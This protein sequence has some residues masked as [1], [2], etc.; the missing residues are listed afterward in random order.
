VA[1][2]LLRYICVNIKHLVTPAALTLSLLTACSST[3]A[4]D[5]ANSTAGTTPPPPAQAAVPKPETPQVG[6]LP[7]TTQGPPTTQVAKEMAEFVIRVEAYNQLREKLSGGLPRLADKATAE[8]VEKRQV[9]LQG[10]IVA[11]RKGAKPGDIFEPSMQTVVRALMA[12]VFS[13]PGQRAELRATIAEEN[14]TGVK[15]AV[16]TRYPDAPVVTMPPEVLKNLPTLPK[17]LEYRFVGES[18]I[19]LD[20]RAHLIVDVMSYALPKN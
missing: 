11:A 6:P 8:E 14:P 3:R 16:N 18:L 4:I 7:S 9:A 10:L 2:L 1:H 17:D 19:L 5:P 12:K 15:L 20:T 13:Q